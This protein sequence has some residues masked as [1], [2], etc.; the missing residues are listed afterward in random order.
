MLL[1][2]DKS[3]NDIITVEFECKDLIRT[4]KSS[5][6]FLYL[7]VDLVNW[8]Y[9]N[10]DGPCDRSGHRVVC[11]NSDLYLLGGYNNR[12]GNDLEPILYKEV[13][14]AFPVDSNIPYGRCTSIF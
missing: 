5:L 14:E 4:F 6:Y 10:V 1:I 13:S 9:W 7:L 11:N 3:L 2:G 12:N 8:L